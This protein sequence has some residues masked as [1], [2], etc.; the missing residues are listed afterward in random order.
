MLEK[1]YFCTEKVT[2]VD[3]RREIGCIKCFIL[4]IDHN[5]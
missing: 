3:E 4:L 1:V 5:C 2:I